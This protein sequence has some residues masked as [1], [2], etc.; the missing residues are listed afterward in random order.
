MSDDP[1]LL[2][3]G[4]YTPEGKLTPG[5]GNSYLFFV[6]RDDVH[7]ILLDLIQSEKLSLK[8]NMFGFDDDELNQAILAL[9]KNNFL[10]SQEISS[11]FYIF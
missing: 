11:I 5:F 9:F 8:I 7:G 3:L 6:G 10:K 1:T 4:K 2:A